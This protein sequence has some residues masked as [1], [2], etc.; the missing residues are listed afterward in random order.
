MNENDRARS[1]RPLALTLLLAMTA[2][3]PAQSKSPGVEAAWA[4]FEARLDACASETGYERSETG[5]PDDA[6][7]P[8]ELEWR[9]CAYRGIEELIIPATRFP[10]AY[11]RLITED[12]ALTRLLGAGKTTR[13]RRRERLD[14]LVA[15]IER[16]EA[17]QETSELEGMRDEMVVRQRDLRRMREIQSLMAR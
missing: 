2:H 8:G 6:L 4:A 13:T 15:E 7:A 17:R 9:G 5:M 10:D 14:A 1:L 12:R 3:A 11:R 16:A